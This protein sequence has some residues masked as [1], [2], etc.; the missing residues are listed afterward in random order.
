M[1]DPNN[2]LSKP[3][4]EPNLKD[5]SIKAWT[6]KLFVAL[7]CMASFYGGWKSHESNM[8]KQCYANGG[9]VI[10]GEKTLLC[11]LS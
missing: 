3:T 9:Q 1:M 4:A 8:V 5:I 11:E 6:Q 10:E 2:R 7:L